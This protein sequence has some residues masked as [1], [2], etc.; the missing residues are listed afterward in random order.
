M[1]ELDVLTAPDAIR[2]ALGVDT[3]G[4]HAGDIARMVTTVSERID[5]LCGPVVRRTITELHDGGDHLIRPRETPVE[6][7]TSVTEWDGTTKTV[8]TEDAWGTAGAAQGYRLRKSPTYPHDV[9]IRRQR[10]GKPSRFAAGPDAVQIVYVAGRYPDTDS[11]GPLFREVATEI[12]RRLWDREAGA[13]A[14]APNPFEPG[15]AAAGSSRF[16]NAVDH[17]IKELAN[18]ELRPPI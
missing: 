8:L 11:V 15:T 7:I 9:A 10:S 13:W 18:A 6:T 14:R 2:A 3:P 16:F 12:L 4:D 1:V 17:V 5:K